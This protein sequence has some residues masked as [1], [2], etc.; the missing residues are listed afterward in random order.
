MH[1]QHFK[2]GVAEKHNFRDIGTAKNSANFRFR[3]KAGFEPPTPWGYCGGHCKNVC[4][5]FFCKNRI[6]GQKHNFCKN[7]IGFLQNSPDYIAKI[8]FHE[9]RFSLL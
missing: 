2:M 1:S 3:L 4:K 6:S 5:K 7:P 8:G 9:K